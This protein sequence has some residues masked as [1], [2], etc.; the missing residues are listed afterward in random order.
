LLSLLLLTTLLT[1]FVTNVAAVVLMFPLGLAAVQGGFLPA[2]PAY[3]ALAFGASAAF[4][5]PA[6]YATNLMVMGPGGYDARDF[7]R[8]GGGLTVLYLALVYGWLISLT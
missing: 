4:L 6:G 3:L 1:N 5:T 2:T 8:L 7:A